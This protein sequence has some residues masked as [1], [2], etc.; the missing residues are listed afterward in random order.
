MTSYTSEDFV[1]T[2]DNILGDFEGNTFGEDALSDVIGPIVDL[3][4]VLEDPNNPDPPDYDGPVRAIQD[5]A[6][7]ILYPIDSA[8]GSIVTDFVGA[9]PKVRDTIYTEG[10]AG[11]L[12]GEDGL[13]PIGLTISNAETDI[14]K[15]SAPLGTW[16]AG[17][18]GNSVKA[19][20]EHYVVMQNVLSDQT[21]PGDD[22]ATFALDNDLIFIGGPFD[23]QKISEINP[24]AKDLNSL[25]YEVLQAGLEPNENSVTENI[26]YSNDY[27]VTLKDDGKLLYRWGQVIK[28]PNDIRLSLSMDLPEEWT[29]SPLLPFIND[30]FKVEKAFLYID[31]T[32]TNNPND[33]I[34]PE[35]YE[36]EA[37]I[38]RLPSYYIDNNGT[39]DNSD[40]DLWR[41]L[42]DSFTGDGT[43]IP[44]GTIF[45]DPSLIIPG[46]ASSDLAE[47]F[48]NEWY[49]SMDRDPFEWAFDANPDPSVQDYVGFRT[50]EEAEL[51][52]YSLSDLVSGPRWRL[53]SNKFGQDL[54]GVE[55]PAIPNSE[56]PFTRDNIKYEVGEAT[57]TVLNLLDWEDGEVSPLAHSNG[58]TQADPDRV[59]ENGVTEN[60]LTLTDQFDLAFYIK[61]DRKPM[62]IYD[63]RLEIEYQ[64]I[65]PVFDMVWRN[66][67]T[68]QGEAWFIEAAEQVGSA[69]LLPEVLDP[70]WL[71]TGVGDLDNDGDKDDLFW[72]N[73]GSGETG[74]WLT[75]LTPDGVQGFDF[76][77][78]ANVPLASNW[79]MGGLGDFDGDS[80]Q[81]DAIWFNTDS[82]EVGVWILDQGQATSY[83]L[84]NLATPTPEE[85]WQIVGVGSFDGEN[86][87]DDVVWQ[88][89]LTGE[90]GISIMDGVSFVEHV[91]TTVVADLSWQ[92]A[93]VSDLD[94]DGIADDIVW[95][96]GVLGTTGL[97]LMDGTNLAEI[98]PD[99]QPAQPLES[100]VIA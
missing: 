5:K 6:G 80:F 92:A 62:D 12:L 13:T 9:V 28:K 34:R 50:P 66:P 78:L 38:G 42:R 61:G 87:I 86:A 37:A 11:N 100:V 58:W 22:S 84:I 18:G 8:F 56:P 93:G 49:T 33:Q 26:A 91:V 32:I 60:G 90:N 31:H 72:R 2:I 55:I 39:P 76:K 16:A 17:L 73:F 41:S 75:D 74:T 44:A 14:F 81:D 27:S 85:G 3:A 10:W 68:G 36:N 71:I 57:T 4:A 95:R 43:Y 21:F 82:R 79:Q 69:P 48:T 94:G 70:N 65:D 40:D 63:A 83:D 53:L 35:D 47:G 97:W 77:L 25:W 7:N 96:H 19:S 46:G 45:K 52:G 29:E 24:A 98:V 89:T 67:S 1:L 59:D 51:A 20:T 30:G 99:L 64:D 88:N 23:G 54:P 15:A